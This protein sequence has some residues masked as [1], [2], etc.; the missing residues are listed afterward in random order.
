MLL[1]DLVHN[2]VAFMTKKFQHKVVWTCALSML[3][4]Q[5]ALAWA[6]MRLIKKEHEFSHIS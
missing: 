6:H 3:Q 1:E 5:R 4:A 2:T